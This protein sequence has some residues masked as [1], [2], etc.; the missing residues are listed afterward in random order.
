M[1]WLL[2]WRQDGYEQTGE[3]TLA[4]EVE[5]LDKSEVGPWFSGQRNEVWRRP[6]RKGRFTDE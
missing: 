1:R 3:E 6:E 5:E 2:H 4:L